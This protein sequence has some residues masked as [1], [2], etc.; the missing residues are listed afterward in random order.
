MNLRSRTLPSLALLL[1]SLAC[2]NPAAASAASP[3]H[4]VGTWAA[5]PVA[6][7]NPD[8]KI[9]SAD[10]TFREIVHV[11]IGG[12]AVRVILTNELGHESLTIGA[13]DVALSAGGSEINPSAAGALTF[14]GRPSITIPPG[15]L[16]VS[17]PVNLKLPP[18]S[19]LAVSIF[20]PAQTISEVTQHSFADQTSYTAA[21]NVAGA[22]TLTSPSEIESWPFLK[23]V[24]VKADN[25]AAAIVAFGDSITDGAHS[26]RNANA[27]WPDVL[28]RR[29]LAGKKTAN[30]G[31]LN[32]GIGGNRILHDGYG[33]SA[34]ARFDRDVLAQAGVKYLIILESINDIGHAQDPHR[35]YDVVSADDLIAGLSQLAT[36]AHTHG[37]K[38][39]GATLTP[40]VGAKYSSPAGEAMRSA[41]N[42]WIRATSQLDGVIDFDKVTRDPANPTVFLPADDSGDNLH[43]GDAGYKAMGDSIDLKLFKK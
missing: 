2:L 32:E 14:N 22:T 35:P 41:I 36:R 31:V 16:A 18:S 25:K 30:L 1:F 38:V 4:W 8:A 34:L 27:R 15:A 26:T 21:G 42:Q 39:F 40:Y 11:S 17:D 6:Q 7:A 10:T 28:A 33:P 43:P 37:I 5:A 23:G 9:G 19:N 13:A 3:D 20:V 29:L 12:P 24:D